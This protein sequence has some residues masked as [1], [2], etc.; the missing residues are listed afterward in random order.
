MAK[1]D[2]IAKQIVENFLVP[3]KDEVIIDE[4]KFKVRGILK[5]QRNIH[6]EMVPALMAVLFLPASA[7]ET[8]RGKARRNGKQLFNKLLGLEKAPLIVRGIKYNIIA[9]EFIEKEDFKRNLKPGLYV[10][11]EAVG[12]VRG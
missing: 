6:D 11:I 4:L 5:E 2:K 10:T 9:S 1:L 7:K 8:T 12:V 3:D